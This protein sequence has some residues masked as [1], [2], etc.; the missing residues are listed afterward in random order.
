M[1]W[2]WRCNLL[3]APPPP[4]SPNHP[5]LFNYPGRPRSQVTREPLLCRR[6]SGPSPRRITMP[7]RPSLPH[8]KYALARLGAPP[9]PALCLAARCQA[10]RAPGRRRRAAAR[11]V[12]RRRAAAA[13]PTRRAPRAPPLVSRRRRVHIPSARARPSLA[14]AHRGCGDEGAR[15]GGGRSAI[16]WLPW[17]TTRRLSPPSLSLLLLLLSL[18]ATRAHV[19]DQIT[20]SLSAPARARRPRSRSTSPLRSRR[21]RRRRRCR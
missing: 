5:L 13:P 6:P 16:T 9:R 8:N 4:A 1:V 12:G 15:G 21:R 3:R 17:R 11:S 2:W 14:A 18:L 7:S 20:S 19:S 10:A